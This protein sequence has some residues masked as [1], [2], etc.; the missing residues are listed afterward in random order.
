MQHTYT[1]R[2]QMHTCA[3]TGL[4]EEGLAGVGGLGLGVGGFE[5]FLPEWPPLCVGEALSCLA[6]AERRSWC[7]LYKEVDE[8][9]EEEE[10]DEEEEEL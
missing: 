2:M 8:E 4:M 6:L 3:Q 10:E 9:E 1:L 5:R 7:M